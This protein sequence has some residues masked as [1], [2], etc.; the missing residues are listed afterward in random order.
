MRRPDAKRRPRGSVPLSLPLLGDMAGSLLPV[1]G[2]SAAQMRVW[3]KDR[4]LLLL[5]PDAIPVLNSW[6]M[7]LIG[8]APVSI[9]GWKPEGPG[10]SEYS[11]SP[12]IGLLRA[13]AR[14]SLPFTFNALWQEKRGGRIYPYHLI[15]YKGPI[16]VSATKYREAGK[17]KPRLLLSAIRR[18]VRAKMRLPEGW[19]IVP[20]DFT[21]CHGHIAFALSA[22]QQLAEDLRSGFH[23]IT[24]DWA[25]PPEVSKKERRRFGKLMNNAMLFGLTPIGLRRDLQEFLGFD[26]GEVAAVRMWELWWQRYPQLSEFR[27]TVRAYVEVAQARKQGLRIISPSGR[28]SAFPPGEILGAVSKKGLAPP[29]PEGVW[30]TVFSAA[31]RAVE[32]DL[33]N[34]LMK[35]FHETREY[36]HG[37]LVLPVYDGILTAAPEGGSAK[38]WEALKVCGLQAAKDLGLTDLDVA[39]KN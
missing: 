14:K 33:L 12:L 17:D 6:E 30:R 2:V 34:R 19:E 26:P 1:D 7:E 9:P 11:A 5:E 29:G 23:E 27:D 18:D 22:D 8:K 28:A 35:H 39:R 25:M 31:F 36:H 38:V 13:R 20:C 37:Q 15:G 4:V 24:G 21:S 32:G 3:W 16:T 10:R